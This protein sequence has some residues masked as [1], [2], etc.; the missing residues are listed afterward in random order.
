MIEQINK[1]LRQNQF[2]TSSNLR[3]N[4]T[5]EVS[6]RAEKNVEEYLLTIND[7]WVSNERNRRK[8]KR[9]NIEKMKLNG[10]VISEYGDEKNGMVKNNVGNFNSSLNLNFSS[11]M[12]NLLEE[13]QRNSYKISTTPPERTA[14]TSV[15]SN[16]PQSFS[17]EIGKELLDS[18]DQELLYFLEKLQIPD[19]NLPLE[20]SVNIG[21]TRITGYFCSDTV[22]NLNNRVLTDLEIKVLEKGLDFAPIQSKINEPKLRQDFAD[23]C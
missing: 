22:F 19:H 3:D 17:P 4:S 10:T 11:I 16:S 7:K 12:S 23:F 13:E 2:N 15:S 6:S 21:A 9:S 18:Q 14:D 20:R 1:T 5:V 8:C